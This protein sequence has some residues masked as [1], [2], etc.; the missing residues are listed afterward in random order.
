MEMIGKVVPKVR[1][2]TK[3]KNLRSG[4]KVGVTQDWEI[5]L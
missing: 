4:S 2:N 1:P 3:S 5:I